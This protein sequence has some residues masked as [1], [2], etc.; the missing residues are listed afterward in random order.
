LDILRNL[1]LQEKHV[2][3][4]VEEVC[5]LEGTEREEV[6]CHQENLNISGSTFLD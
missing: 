6:I 2:L 5:I 1:E 4:F 3:A